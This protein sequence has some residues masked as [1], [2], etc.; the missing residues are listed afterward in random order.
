MG[1]R[2]TYGALAEAVGSP[3]ASRAVGQALRMNPLPIITPCHR[4]VAA[5]GGPGGFCGEGREGEPGVLVKMRLL[6]NEQ[7]W[8]GEDLKRR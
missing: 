8:I 5:N 6:A 1:G 2:L 3:R 4:V 7:K